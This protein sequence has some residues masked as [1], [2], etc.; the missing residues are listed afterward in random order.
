MGEQ[1]SFST[2]IMRGGSSKALFLKQEELPPEEDERRKLIL[3]LF[4]SPDARQIDGLGGADYLTSKCAIMGPPSRRDAD[5]D[6]TF[7]QVSVVN[8]VVSFDVN[9]GNIS[10]AAALFAIEE[11]YVQVQEPKT[12]V[13]VHNTNTGKILRIMVPVKDDVPVIEGDFAIDGVPGTGAEIEIDFSDTSGACTGSLLPTGSPQD[14]IRVDG[15]DKDL[16]VSIVDVGN[17]CVFIHAADLGVSGTEL[18]G[19]FSDAT[20]DL[21]EAIRKRSAEISG[22]SSHVLPLQVIVSEPQDYSTLVPGRFV[23]AGQVDVVARQFLEKMGHKAYAG[24]GSACIAVA[25]KIDGTLVR[26]VCRKRDSAVFNIG[27]PSGVIPISVDV[28]RSEE[29]WHVKEVLYSRTARRL[30][31]G[32]AFVR[33]SLF[34]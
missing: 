22:I 27:H 16:R 32:T 29:G 3:A 20:L 7:A 18:P 5:I 19:Q 12:T 8:P 4:G 21:L 24:T 28:E 9:C 14:V 26:Q 17:V 23:K 10:A 2:V 25:S 34:R 33:N 1:R 11:S 30:M 15:L 6:Y 31:Q 13:R